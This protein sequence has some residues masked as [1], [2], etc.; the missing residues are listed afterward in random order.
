MTVPRE[1]FVEWAVRF[2]EGGL[3]TLDALRARAGGGPVRAEDVRRVAGSL[4]RPVAAVA[5]AA[6]FYADF[7]HGE[8]RERHIRVCEG[9]SCFAATGG[10]HVERLDELLAAAP[11]GA[12]S[13]RRVHC[14]G[15]CYASPTALDGELPRTG[16]DLGG[17][18]TPP[19]GAALPRPETLPDSAPP[20]PFHVDARRPVTLAG[21]AGGEPPW[22]AWP[23]AVA[24]GARARERVID[25]VARAGLR[26]RGGARF[27]VAAKWSAAATGTAPRFVV[28]NGDE[29][30]PGS[31]CDRLLM[32]QD[33]HRVLEGLALAALAIGA[34]HGVVL[35]RSE[36]PGAFARMKAAV[37]EA[38]EAGHLGPDVHGSGVAFDVEIVEGAGSYVAGEET[39]LL[40]ALEGL[41]GSARSRPPYP[42]FRGLFGRPTAV[43]NVETLAAV[44]WIMRHGGE[45]YA[46]LGHA[47][48]AGTKLVCL[49]ERF[50][51]PGVYEVEFGTPLTTIVDE[52][53]GGLHD[54]TLRALQVGGPLGGFLAPDALDTPLLTGALAGRGVPLGHGSLVAIDT[55]ISARALLRHVWAF[56]ASESCGACAP[57]RVGSL[58]GSELAERFGTDDGPEVPALLERLMDVMETASLCAFGRGVPGSVRSLLRVYREELGLGPR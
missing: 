40:H 11:E 58:R 7:A 14:L 15:F 38:R 54:G 41:R 3:G 44:P 17:L 5:G 43:N 50:H 31:F 32:E 23:T 13:L 56:A 47:E 53:G 46:D 36:Y 26:G 45:A 16:E 20:V 6:S 27:P 37:Q 8:T 51:R 29:G 4:N 35:V 52:L 33:P 2:G 18:L 25:E 22:T 30:D 42:V 34:A 39:A 21:L 57:C 49:N 48:E 24:D 28:A 55:S 9:T 1:G 10:R 19:P 12:F